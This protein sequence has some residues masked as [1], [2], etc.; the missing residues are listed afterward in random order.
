MGKESL[1]FKLEG[2]W[3]VLGH[4]TYTKMYTAS[5]AFFEALWE[6]GVRNCFVNLG[7]DH[8][9]IMEAMAKGLKEKPDEFPR[10]YTCPNE[11]VALSMADGY[12]RVTNKPQ[13][14]I[15]HVDV[16]TS[17]LGAAIH[18]ASAGRAPVLIFAGLSPFT[19]EGELR[20]SR[21]EYIHWLQDVP[22]QKQIVAQ[23]CRY[24]GEIK[25]GKNIKQMVGR[26]LQFATSDPKGPVYLM[27]ARE[28]ME[29][30]IQPY[31]IHPEHWGPCE[32]AALPESHV[33]FIA[34]KLVD[35]K[36]PLVITGYSGR[37][38]QS[39]KLLTDLAD[40]VPG[41]RVLDT[42]GCDMCFPADHPGWLGMR[43][44]SDPSIETADLILVVDCDVPWI[45]T[46]CR[47]QEAAT[48][49]HI[50]ID[51]LKKLMPLFYLPAVR[52][53]TAD[54]ATALIQIIS[55]I[56][57]S[58]NLQ[59]ALQLPVHKERLHSRQEQ[60]QQLIKSLDDKCTLPPNTTSFNASFLCQKLRELAPSNTVYAVEAVT[61]STL[62]SDQIRATVPGQWINCGGGGLGWSG[63][64]ALGIKLAV[65]AAN[66]DKKP[67]VVQIVG[68]G[69][70]L[71]SVPSSVYW[72]SHRCQIP[73]LTIVLN[74][75]GWNAPRRSMLLV[76]P[77]GHGSKADNRELNI[78]FEPS[79][80]Y[81][82]I[83]KAASDGNIH[84][85][86]VKD[87][88]ELGRV[89]KEAIEVVRGGTSAV[90]DAH[91]A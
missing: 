70:F 78:S 37:N 69:T 42:G 9:S 47:P 12:A 5:Y 77:D 6:L 14:V 3:K 59:E 58:T 13:C 51:P 38:H 33:K 90:I 66:P 18:N 35:A 22:D 44:G 87:V 24:A 8:P 82:G 15:I 36:E 65:D 49:I 11:M 17:G 1:I 54:A 72:I 76:H 84:A 40:A 83:A 85:A 48:V 32:T 63:G 28:V 56:R 4:Y 81:S 79:P 61:N 68:D 30:D 86:R 57:S 16:G 80:D 20:G 50:D 39:V 53:Y 25:T 75:K 43:L 41:L 64:G 46:Q 26:A 88:A 55:F 45:P 34:D 31:T 7:S 67:L 91:V 74:N 52:R 21:T 2:F 23:Y 29:E 71:F 27:G 10:I 60:Y 73:I 89:L 19:L 62:V